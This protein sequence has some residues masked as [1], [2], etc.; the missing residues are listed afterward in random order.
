MKLLSI[1]TVVFNDLEGIKLTSSSVKE[2][3]LYQDI[4]YIVID[5]GSTDGT[6]ELVSGLDFVTTFISEKDK[7][8][9]NAMNKGL[10]Y[11]EAEYVLFLNAGDYL[12][13]DLDIKNLLYFP[14]KS[15]III[16][17][18]NRFDNAQ[19]SILL[20]YSIK[21]IY[22]LLFKVSPPC[23]Q[24]MFI[25][26]SCFVVLGNYDESYKLVADNVWFLQYIGQ[27]S[28]VDSIR[29]ID[30]TTVNYNIE[31]RSNSERQSVIKERYIMIRNLKVSLAWKSILHMGL[32]F[33]MFK[34]LLL[35][36]I[37]HR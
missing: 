21:N 27:N 11:V 34:F 20:R 15:D 1:I 4:D 19:N 8:I 37:S 29:V 16:G 25:K 23:H 2:Y 36:A 12:E 31:G 30:E 9:Y 35:K 24:A 17:Q 14:K 10:N 33:Y 7:G 26:A 3:V 6:K 22:Q 28:S 5:G 18:T 32:A 13:P